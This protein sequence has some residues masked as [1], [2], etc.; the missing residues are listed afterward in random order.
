MAKL[1]FLL[2]ATLIIPSLSASKCEADVTAPAAA[3]QQ[4]VEQDGEACLSALQVNQ[5][6][7]THTQK[8]VQRHLAGTAHLAS[9]GTCGSYYYHASWGWRADA[10]PGMCSGTCAIPSTSDGTCTYDNSPCDMSCVAGDSGKQCGWYYYAKDWG[11]REDQWAGAC[12]GGGTCT[13]PNTSDGT[14]TYDNNP[15][16][17]TCQG[18]PAP[19]PSP[20]GPGTGGHGSTCGSYYYHASYGWRA[21]PWPS[22]CSAT[23]SC[24]LPDTSDASVC[25]SPGPC[26]MTC[27]ATAVPYR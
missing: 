7:T 10:W 13:R 3:I 5:V 23:L 17:M 21:D 19:S 11:W 20:A 6:K 9:R 25:S 14:C 2:F 15:C 8:D 18:A 1:S 12:S 22:M 16:A 4:D 26:D 24:T 27:E